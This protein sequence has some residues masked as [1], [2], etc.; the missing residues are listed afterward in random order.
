MPDSNR[1]RVL[2]ISRSLDLR[3]ELVTLLSGYGYF[4]EFCQSRMEGTRKFRAHKQSIVILDV[5]D[6]ILLI[7]CCLT[8]NLSASCFCV[9]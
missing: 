1:H 2:I 5:P 9:I 3:N 4:V 8:P 6:S 7:S